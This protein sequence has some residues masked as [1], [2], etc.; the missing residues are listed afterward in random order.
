LFVSIP[1][2]AFHILA[3]GGWPSFQETTK[4]LSSL[5]VIKHPVRGGGNDTHQTAQKVPALDLIDGISPDV[6]L[7]ISTAKVAI[8]NLPMNMITCNSTGNVDEVISLLYKHGC[9]LGNPF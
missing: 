3:G 2:T 9:S 7:T 4:C 1:S 8:Q 5:T 6:E